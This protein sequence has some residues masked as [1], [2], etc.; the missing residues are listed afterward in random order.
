[1]ADVDQ[2]RQSGFISSTRHRLGDQILADQRFPLEEDFAA[3][4]S[5]DLLQCLK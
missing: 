4:C 5:A 1:M 3:L 2:V